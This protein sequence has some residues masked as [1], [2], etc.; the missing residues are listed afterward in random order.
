MG[1]YDE[2]YD[3]TYLHDREQKSDKKEANPNKLQNLLRKK[4]SIAAI[5]IVVLFL[6]TGLLVLNLRDSQD[7]RS[8]AS[9][10]EIAEVT[11]EGTVVCG[12]KTDTDQCS[13]LTLITDNGEEYSLDSSASGQT[14][15][16]KEGEKVKIEGSIQTTGSTIPLI[17]VKKVTPITIPFF[18]TPTPSPN[19]NWTPTPTVTQE[20]L[21]AP[22]P[23]PQVLKNN[24]PSPNTEYLTVTFIIQNKNTLSGQNINV[25]GFLVGGYVGVPGCSFEPKCNHSQFI[26]SDFN[27][28]NRDTALDIL[29]IGGA[30]DKEGEFAPGQDF[31]SGA[32]V[33]LE[34]ET[35]Y[36]EKTD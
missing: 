33:V 35:V 19:P 5:G 30:D 26:L 28:P 27:S 3:I 29:Y 18:K 21:V 34:N 9:E 8:K 4:S 25:K 20:D 7:I 14:S 2:P 36:L 31:Y 23:T 24:T 15:G 22:T 6:G 16:L 13:E 1:L 32:K 11:T 17:T 12:E 10:N